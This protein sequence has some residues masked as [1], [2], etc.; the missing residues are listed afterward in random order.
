M[1][2]VLACSV[3]V[4]MLDVVVGPPRL[5]CL[6]DLWPGACIGERVVSKPPLNIRYLELPL[7]VK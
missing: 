4:M 2:P 5:V 6:L 7:M 3:G 1:P